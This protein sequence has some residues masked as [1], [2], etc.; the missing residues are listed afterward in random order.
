MS[1]ETFT[2]ITKV[3][4]EMFKTYLFWNEKYLSYIRKF[5]NAQEAC[6]N[7]KTYSLQLCNRGID[8]D[9]DTYKPIKTDEELIKYYMDIMEKYLNKISNELENLYNIIRSSS[10][11]AQKKFYNKE[12]Y[13]M[14]MLDIASQAESRCMKRRQDFVRRCLD[15][16]NSSSRRDFL[17]MLL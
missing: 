3:R 8:P 17:S 16:L 4:K 2:P 1:N 6:N 13:I 7:A 14:R 10:G 12:T 15:V 11:D 5:K 9:S